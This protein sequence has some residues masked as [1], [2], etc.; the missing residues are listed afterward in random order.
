MGVGVFVNEKKNIVDIDGIVPNM[1]LEKTIF[2]NFIT[3]LLLLL[4]GTSWKRKW[5]KRCRLK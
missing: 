4:P 3:R 5:P 2:G 1:V